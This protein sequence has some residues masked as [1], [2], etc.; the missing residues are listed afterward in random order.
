MT[1]NTAKII[2]DQF[3]EIVEKFSKKSCFEFNECDF[4]FRVRDVYSNK[5]MDV[6]YVWFDQ[7]RRRHDVVVTIDITNICVSDLTSCKWVEYLEKLAREFI[8]DICPKRIVI[9]KDEPK[10]CRTEPPRWCPMPCRHITTVIKKKIPI[11]KEPECEIIIEE[12]CECIPECVRE[13]CVPK[14]EIIIKYTNEKPWKC[15]DVSRLVVEPEKNSHEWGTFK[16]NTDYNSHIWNKKC[17]DTKPCCGQNFTTGNT[18]T[19]SNPHH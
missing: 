19:N 15:G 4:D 11:K 1:S 7:C 18:G 12:D 5:L 3:L 16:G 17:C 2:F 6:V 8:C 9:V 13:P 10:K 14:Q